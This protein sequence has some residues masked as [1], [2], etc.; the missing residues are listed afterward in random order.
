VLRGGSFNFLAGRA[1]SACRVGRLPD[2]RNYY[3]GFRVLY[4]SPID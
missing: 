3:I 1:R 4:S 2:Y